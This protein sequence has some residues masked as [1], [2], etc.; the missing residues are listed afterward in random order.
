[1]NVLAQ[2]TQLR[3]MNDL[4]RLLSLAVLAVFAAADVGSWPTINSARVRKGKR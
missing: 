3:T 4:A 1:M 2:K